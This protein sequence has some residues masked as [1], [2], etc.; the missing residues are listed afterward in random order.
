MN[1]IR[2]YLNTAY[3]AI[4]PSW[5]LTLELLE[6]NLYQYFEYK[7]IIKQAGVFNFETYRKN[8]LISTLKDIQ[9]TIIKQVLNLGLSPYAKAKIKI[10]EDDN[11]DEFIN[12]LTQ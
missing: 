2:G 10:T 3:G 1:G 8:P 12:S 4:D 6:D 5:E 7:N 11:S 9:A